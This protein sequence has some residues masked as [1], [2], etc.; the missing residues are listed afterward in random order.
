MASTLKPGPALEALPSGSIATLSARVPP[1]I[2]AEQTEACTKNY[3][4]CPNCL[5][6]ALSRLGA[7]VA[8]SSPARRVR[9]AGQITVVSPT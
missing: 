5:T 7:R 1:A 9:R 3:G 6:P 4:I 2:Q 8:R